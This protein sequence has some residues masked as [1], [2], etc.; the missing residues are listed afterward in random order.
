MLQLPS[1]ITHVM[2]DEVQR[3]PKLLDV[4]HKLIENKKV[5]QTFILTGSSAR[6][7]KLGGANLL[8]GRAALRHLFSLTSKELQTHFDLNT[9][10]NWGG[11][12]VAFRL[13]HPRH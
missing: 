11:G 1:T 3:V 5:S 9:A 6:K 13:E 2:V 10:L 12:G 8:A 4:D 7:L